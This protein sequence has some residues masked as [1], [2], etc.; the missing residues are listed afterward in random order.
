MPIGDSD[1]NTFL[2][3]ENDW[4][5]LKPFVLVDFL[6][7]TSQEQII[8]QVT[9]LLLIGRSMEEISKKVEGH[10]IT[11]FKKVFWI[12][13]PCGTCF[14]V[15]VLSLVINISP[16]RNDTFSFV[17]SRE[18]FKLIMRFLIFGKELLEADDLLAKVRFLINHQ[19]NTISEIYIT[20]KE[21]FVY[22]SMMLWRERLSLMW[23]IK[24]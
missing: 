18:R 12:I 21:L 22:R 5:K 20:H 23:Y 10:Y 4:T 11:A 14:S 6:G 9:Q 19:N 8:M 13:F 24:R 16:L 15:I 3:D 2:F 7:E 1:T 17:M